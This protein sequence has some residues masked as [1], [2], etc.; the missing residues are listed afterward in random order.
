MAI[1]TALVLLA[2]L[3]LWQLHRRYAP[4]RRQVIPPSSRPV[5]SAQRD[6]VVASAQRHVGQGAPALTEDDVITFGLA[7]EATNDV[8]EKL[9]ADK[10]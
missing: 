1:V 6:P 5:R 7:L 2:A 3:G 10:D 8:V 9:L 4:R